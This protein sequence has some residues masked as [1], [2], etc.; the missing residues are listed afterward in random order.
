MHPA[1]DARRRAKS[2]AER[3]AEAAEVQRRLKLEAAA[4]RQ[5]AAAATE[6]SAKR[7]S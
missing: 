6:T 1:Q 2:P 4:R 7:P 3:G 5:A